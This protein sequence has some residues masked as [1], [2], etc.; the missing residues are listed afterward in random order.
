MSVE[1]GTPGVLGDTEPLSGFEFSD[2][3]LEDSW[4]LVAPPVPPLFPAGV[5]FPPEFSVLPPSVFT[6]FTSPLDVLVP[7]PS[8][9]LLFEVSVGSSWLLLLPPE[10]ERLSG[11]T[12]VVRLPIMLMMIP[13]SFKISG[14]KLNANLKLRRI[15]LESEKKNQD[16]AFLTIFNVKNTGA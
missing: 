15:N 5:S 6:S 1:V 3:P 12:R 14:A 13:R 4:S 8:V 11:C 7:L 9:E 10:P 2:D 16:L